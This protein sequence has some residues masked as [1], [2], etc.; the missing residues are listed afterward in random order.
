MRR[1][2]LALSRLRTTRPYVV[3]TAL[4]ALVLFAVSIQFIFPDEGGDPLSLPGF[5]LGLGTAAP[6]IWWRRAPFLCASVISVLTPAMTLY[7]R[8][9]PDVCYGGLVASAGT[10]WC[11]RCGSWRPG[12]PCSRRR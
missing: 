5:A 12:I 1:P 3:D 4:A 7:H 6:L 11:T 10:T 2:F 8:P 9:P